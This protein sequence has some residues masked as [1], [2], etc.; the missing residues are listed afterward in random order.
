MT[1]DST[2][3][4]IWLVTRQDPYHLSV[5]GA[6]V[7]FQPRS[8]KKI[9]HVLAVIT[10]YWTWPTLFSHH[11]PAGECQLILCSLILPRPVHSHHVSCSERGSATLG[12]TSAQRTPFNIYPCSAAQKTDARTCSSLCHSYCSQDS[13]KLSTKSMLWSS[14]YTHRCMGQYYRP[15]TLYK[16]CPVQLQSAA[17]A[18][19]C[20]QSSPRRNQLCSLTFAWYDVQVMWKLTNCLR[21]QLQYVLWLTI[22]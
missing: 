9:Y 10:L 17:S 2:L 8:K 13:C 1:H 5:T 4:L 22:S 7:F 3:V 15:V 14:W 21:H 18:S 6:V 12:N 20:G 11:L 19:C 16:Q